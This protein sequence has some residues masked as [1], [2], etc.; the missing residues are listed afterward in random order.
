MS[1]YTLKGSA[2]L[3]ERIESDLQRIA[4]V[5][6]PHSI[7][8]VLL[9]G[10]G[11][12]EGTPFINPDGTQIPFNDYDLVVVV[13]KR[14]RKIRSLFSS[15]ERQL[16]DA[17]GLAVDLYPYREKSLPKCEFSLLNYE[18]K[19]GHKVVWGDPHILNAMP[20]YT[21]NA[22]PLPEGTRLLLNRGKLLLDIKQ[23]L[24]VPSALS[25]E[26]RI[27]LIKFIHKVWLA[28]GDCALL[29]ARQYDISYAAKKARIRSIGACPG[30]D[31]VIEGYQKAVALK[32]WGDFQILEPFNIAHEFL[33]TRKLFLRF[34]A[35]YREQYTVHEGRTVKNMLLNLRWNGN[36]ETDHPRENLYNLLVELLQDNTA[37]PTDRFYAMQRRFS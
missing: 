12:G 21:H 1:R 11:R 20:D 9:G 30:R 15:L 5:A 6:S 18:M 7:A 33:Q 32:E 2:Q 16:T 24:A 35:W 3:D 25:D 28:L 8:G 19:H 36:L 22:V 13:E 17:L 26:E 29:A 37:H 4:E 27:R 34:M 23:R 10:Y 31:A 14:S